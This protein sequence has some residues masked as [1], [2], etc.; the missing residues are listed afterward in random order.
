[1]S[2]ILGIFGVD[3]KDSRGR[4]SCGYKKVEE[5]AAECG[6]LWNWVFLAGRGDEEASPIPPRQSAVANGCATVRAVSLK[7]KRK[8]LQKETLLA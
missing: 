8:T 3:R 5:R 6:I 1:M 4:V 7:S 2:G